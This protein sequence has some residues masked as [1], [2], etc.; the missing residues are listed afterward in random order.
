[1]SSTLPNRD[2]YM[3]KFLIVDQEGQLT[4]EQLMY[5]QH[6]LERLRG[7]VANDRGNIEKPFHPAIL[8]WFDRFPSA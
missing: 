2:L 7:L 1:V 3:L 4:K 8:R 5:F 6:D